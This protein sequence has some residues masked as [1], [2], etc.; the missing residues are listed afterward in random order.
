MLAGA[1]LVPLAAVASACLVFNGAV[2][3]D[4]GGDA[5]TSE[6]VDGA[7]VP[8]GP[9][10]T[11]AAPMKCC[12]RP[13]TGGG[14][15]DYETCAADCKEAGGYYGYA[16]ISTSECTGETVCCAYSPN[17]SSNRPYSVSMC[18]PAGTCGEPKGGTE[19]CQVDG[20]GTCNASGRVC[21]LGDGGDVPPIYGEC[22]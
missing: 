5:G 16:C 13:P 2:V 11:C 18:V 3:T 1:C 20:G 12:A 4:D 7:G 14:P 15:W 10:G 6:T 17:N 21:G 22:L 9:V 19:L 8:C